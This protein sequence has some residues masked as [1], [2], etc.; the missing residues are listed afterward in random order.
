MLLLGDE[1]QPHAA[2]ADLFPQLVRANRGAGPLGDWFVIDRPQRSNRVMLE[3]TA[4]F[5]LR[6]DQLD[7]VLAQGRLAA[8]RFV[9]EGGSLDGIG[10]I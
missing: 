4:Q 9:E 10:D 2:F 1:D 8:A 7:D 6:G 3:E 5:F